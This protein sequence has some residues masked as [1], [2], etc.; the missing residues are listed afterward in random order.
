MQ[1]VV[2]APEATS[3]PARSEAKLTREICGVGLL[4]RTLLTAQRTGAS[5]V[6][7]VWP[8]SLPLELAE[9][10]LQSRLLK[11]KDNVRLVQVEHLIPMFARAGR[12]CRTNWK[13]NSSGCLGIGLRMQGPWRSFPR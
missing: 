7:L 5:E 2:L 12:I 4:E 6:L 8:Q 11:K 3:V 9:G 10:T 1:I 13:T